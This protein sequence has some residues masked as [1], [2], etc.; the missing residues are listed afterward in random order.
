MAIFKVGDDYSVSSFNAKATASDANATE[1]FRGSTGKFILPIVLGL[2]AILFGI[3]G[4]MATPSFDGS[5]RAFSD[6]VPRVIGTFLLNESSTR[7]PG[8]WATQLGKV[9]AAVTTASGAILLALAAAREAMIGL[10]ARYIYSSHMLVIGDTAVARRVAEE[11][12]RLGNRVVQVV[13]LDAPKELPFGVARIR[14]GFDA[15]AIVKSVAPNHARFVF[16]D[17]GSNIRTLGLGR[18]L[19]ERIPTLAGGASTLH[20]LTGRHLR[21]QPDGL[22]FR[23][24]DTLLAGQFS[25]LVD[26]EIRAT[27]TG[28]LLRP[29]IFDEN[30]LIARQ[31]LAKYPLFR[32]ADARR[33]PRVHAVLVGFSGLAEALVDQIMLT[34]IAGSLALPRITILDRDA[35]HH[36]REFRVRRPSVLDTLEIAFVEFDIETDLDIAASGSG[37]LGSLL[38]SEKSEGLTAI[39]VTLDADD[40]VLRSA[41]QI[42]RFRERTGGLDAAIFYATNTTDAAHNTLGRPG[43]DLKRTDRFIRMDAPSEVALKAIAEFAKA[44]L[45]ART[46]HQ[47][48]ASGDGAQKPASWAE[49][50]E[51][52]RR[53]NMRSSDHIPAKLWSLGIEFSTL[54]DDGI[55]VLP[56]TSRRQLRDL[57]D[58]AVTADTQAKLQALG[59]VEHERWMIDRKLDGWTY[60]ETRNDQRLTHPLLIPSAQ[61]EEMPAEVAKDIEQIRTVLRFVASR[62]DAKGKASKS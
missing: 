31:T 57:V 24:T 7:D 9:L 27:P 53:A 59:R 49:L 11:L 15:D 34:S 45:L 42:R 2:A 25:D 29:T 52:L 26:A 1:I 44:D 21:G 54:D 51:T 8:N 4:W 47:N 58:A 35:R 20:R 23:I 12:R 28:Q 10:L 61:L 37:A 13:P 50:P 36:E 43:D 46:L 41:L 55:P 19:L 40:R 62:G 6:I 39:F 60:G 16:V 56:E 48:Y 17:T 38:A 30:R 3:G 5:F 32:I 22:V 18:A 33:Q 14:L